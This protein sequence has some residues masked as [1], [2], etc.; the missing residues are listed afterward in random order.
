MPIPKKNTQSMAAYKEIKRRILSGGFVADD[1]LREINVASQ[2][3]MGRTPVREALRRLEDEGLLTHEPRLGLVVTRI[4]QRGVTE[5]YAMREVLEGAAAEFAA[6]YATDAEIENMEA[7]LEDQLKPNADAV[8]LNLI[9]HRA[10]YAAAHNSHL[11]RSLSAVTDS[12]YLLGRSTLATP[13]RATKAVDEHLAILVA[14]RARDPQ[15]AAD[16][17]KSHIRQAYLERLRMLRELEVHHEPEKE[18]S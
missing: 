18:T 17:A 16:A 1:R 10:I 4:D 7:I 11:I 9:F 6:R 3:G 15:A 2:L 12:T 8:A 5:L 14:I 13:E